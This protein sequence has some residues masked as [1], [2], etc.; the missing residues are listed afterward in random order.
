[1]SL[2]FSIV[3]LFFI[4]ATHSHFNLN[5]CKL[6]PLSIYSYIFL[7]LVVFVHVCIDVF[8]CMYLHIYVYVIIHY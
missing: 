5:A 1:M 8:V 6:F 4:L 3:Q 2:I 7:Y